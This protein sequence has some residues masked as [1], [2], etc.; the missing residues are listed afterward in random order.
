[1]KRHIVR[2]LTLAAVLSAAACRQAD[3]PMPPTNETVTNEIG[4]IGRDL[5]N[6]AGGNPDGP[7]DLASDLGHYAEDVAR[8]PAAAAELSRRL[9]DALAGRK[10]ELSQVLPVAHTSWVAVAGRQLSE[11]QIEN[12]Q[13][14]MRS[15]LM[16]LGVDEQ[17]AQAAAAQ[18]AVVQQ[19]VTARHRR[20]YELL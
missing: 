20:W 3:G 2:A 11:K 13:D 17:K 6:V 1:V 18:V 15:Q 9:G 10:F 4:D 19:T 16:T 7:N 5:L 12:L 14:E 8:G